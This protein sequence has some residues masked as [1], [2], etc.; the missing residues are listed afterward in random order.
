MTALCYRHCYYTYFTDEQNTHQ[1][2]T[3]YSA[4]KNYVTEAYLLLGKGGPNVPVSGKANHTV[5]YRV[6]PPC[7]QKNSEHKHNHRKKPGCIPE[8]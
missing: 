6:L 1:W 8:C 7:Y 2:H 5:A 3:C 4:F